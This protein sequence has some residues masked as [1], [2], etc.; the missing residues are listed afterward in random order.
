MTR[1][2][3][4]LDITGTITELDLDAPQGS[5]A[6]LKEAVGNIIQAVDFA[7]FCTYVDE[8]GLYSGAVFNPYA[9]ALLA[10]VYGLGAVPINGPMVFVGPVDDEGDSEG[11]APEA[12]ARIRKAVGMMPRHYP[13]FFEDGY[14]PRTVDPVITIVSW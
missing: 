7:E 4:R 8:E 10:A 12:A 14:V 11:L 2:A 1:L 9:S 3:L 13:D 5:Y 6:V